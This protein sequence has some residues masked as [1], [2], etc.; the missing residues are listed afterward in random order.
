[1]KKFNFRSIKSR[2]I[3]AFSGLALLLI[4]VV[5][6]T[7]SQ[8]GNVVVIGVKLL[9]N[10]QPS[11]M[12][13]EAV[14]SELRNTNILL[15]SYLLNGEASYVAS[16]DDIWEKKIL[17]IN[18]TINNLK[19]K[20]NSAENLIL[21]E[22]MTRLEERI[23]KKQQ[24]IIENASFSGTNI[25]ID[26]T[27]F[28]EFKADSLMDP[29]ALQTWLS[30]EILS[31][32]GNS[33]NNG[34]LFLEELNPL[35]I[36]FDETTQTLYDNLKDE[37]K[38]LGNEAFDAIDQFI[39]IEIIVLLLYIIICIVLFRFIIRK[40]LKSVDIVN[41][42]VKILSEGNIPEEKKSTDDE[43]GIVLEEI[44]SLSQNLRNVKA[45]ALEVG[46]GSFDN[47]ISVFNNEGEVGS[48]LAEMRDSLKKVSEEAVIRNWSNKGFA[49]LGDILRKYSN[50]LSMLTDHVI[51]YI[52]KYLNAN[53]GSIFIVDENE[54]N[55]NLQL[56]ATYA[57][58]R[59]KFIEKN[60]APGQGLVGQVYLE[61][62]SI[63]LKDI[64]QNYVTITSGLG[65]ATPKSIFI[66][67][68]MVNQEIFGVI[69]LASFYELKGYEREFLNRVGE[70]IASSIQAVK[71]N[72]QTK[73]LLDES[74]Q[75]TEQMRSQEEEMR[76]NMEELQAT[77][78]EMERGQSENIERVR[79]IEKSGIA[80]IEFNPD[81]I[82][83]NADNTFL[84]LFGYSSLSE[85]QGKHHRIFVDSEYAAS[86]NYQA[87]WNDLRN[88]VNKEGVFERITKGGSKIFI[89]GAYTYVKDQNGYIRKI[90][91]FAIDVSSIY[92]QQQALL[93]EK[94]ALI[95]QVE[96]INNHLKTDSSADLEALRHQTLEIKEQLLKQ[97]QQNEEKLKRSLGLEKKKLKL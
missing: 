44:Y 53:Q 26:I 59:K 51:T 55:T 57:Y 5:G 63:Y 92:R 25:T 64:P 20:W 79:A 15:H 3:L 17:P 37:T 86:D 85:I 84:N 18:D 54:E 35:I 13:V 76:Q 69:E 38:A 66:V 30:D 93:A 48:S 22:K 14:R 39:I 81:G 12:Q 40:I 97:L 70:N 52:V 94:E 28:P 62:E 83:V 58:D 19:E 46:K 87:F 71:I 77:Q 88:G 36:S 23:R 80:F 41:N 43:L 90:Y 73:Q 4:I 60:V 24:E 6:I 32:Q 7:L 68:L 10:R 56:A 16:I 78:E 45:F 91:K 1:M 50:N 8:V 95:A 21:L 47:D 9:D 74:Q 31:Q 42:E 49:E 27:S 65:Q 89:K 2:L 61:K 33:P 29:V 82:V 11:R 75:M 96:E 72:E 67:P 34:K